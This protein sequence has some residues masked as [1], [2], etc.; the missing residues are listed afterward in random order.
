MYAI[1]KEVDLAKPYEDFKWVVE[2][3]PTGCL[4]PT[5]YYYKTKED[6]QKQ[7]DAINNQMD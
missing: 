4:T 2:K 7:A 3:H 5:C 6:A 1:I